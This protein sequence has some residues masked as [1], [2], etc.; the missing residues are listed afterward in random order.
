MAVTPTV[1]DFPPPANEL[2]SIDRRR[3]TLSLPFRRTR[4]RLY[5]SL[6][7][8][9]AAPFSTL[10]TRIRIYNIRQRRILL[11]RSVT[12]THARTLCLDARTLARTAVR[13]KAPCI[14]AARDTYARNER[15]RMCRFTSFFPKTRERYARN[16]YTH[17]EHSVLHFSILPRGER[18]ACYLNGSR[19][20]SVLSCAD[21][22][23]GRARANETESARRPG[24][25][26]TPRCA[27]RAGGTWGTV[28]SVHGV[29]S[30]IKNS[31]RERPIGG[32]RE[33]PPMSRAPLISYVQSTPG[34]AH[35]GSPR[36]VAKAGITDKPIGRIRA[37]PFPSPFSPRTIALCKVSV[38]LSARESTPS[39]R[40]EKRDRGRSGPP[41]PL[42]LSR[43]S[44]G[45][46]K[47]E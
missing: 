27:G 19:N 31:R 13:S 40:A 21:G 45:A 28:F 5:S 41:L 14:P 35:S 3:H 11:R 39:P 32:V 8:L 9:R 15:K 43:T 44:S 38:F 24:A 10:R 2:K 46:G 37:L 17:T 16:T 42:R 36:R 29:N 7:R 18:H 22:R 20:E 33:A 47:P 34:T 23:T 12:R 30:G 25:S 1:R 26:E 6:R 4:A